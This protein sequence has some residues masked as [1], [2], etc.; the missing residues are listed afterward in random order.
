VL[1]VLGIKQVSHI[2][3]N[4][5]LTKKTGVP[6]GGV[7]PAVHCSVCVGVFAADSAKRQKTQNPVFGAL[8]LAPSGGRHKQFND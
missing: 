7:V 3:L 6:L 1:V 5:R 4:P 8:A 2:V